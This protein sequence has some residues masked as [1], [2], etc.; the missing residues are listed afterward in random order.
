MRD[1]RVTYTTVGQ[2]VVKGLQCLH[3]NR[4]GMTNRLIPLRRGGPD[5]NDAVKKLDL[6]EAAPAAAEGG[7][8]WH[9]SAH[10]TEF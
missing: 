7:D 2:L 3:P 9:A 8:S 6:T 10:D 1:D 4:N 5:T